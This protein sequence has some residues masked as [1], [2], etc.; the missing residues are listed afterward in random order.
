MDDC[1]AYFMKADDLVQDIRAINARISFYGVHVED[2]TANRLVT[3]TNSQFSIAQSVFETRTFPAGFAV[4]ILANAGSAGIMSGVD[5]FT[6]QSTEAGTAGL[7]LGDGK[8]IIRDISIRSKSLCVEV[9]RSHLSTFGGGGNLTFSSSQSHCFLTWSADLIVHPQEH[10]IDCANYGFLMYQGSKGYFSH[11]GGS[12]TANTGDPVVGL[13][14]GSTGTSAYSSV[15]QNGAGDLL[16][17]GANAAG[18]WE[19]QTDFAAGSPQLCTFY[20]LSS[21]MMGA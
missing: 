11:I 15:V 1:H 6:D 19:T 5:I 2:A 18:D 9:L 8:A 14:Q 3:L 13:F 7:Y 10:F 12:L 17:V 21:F 4:G 16:R 20:S